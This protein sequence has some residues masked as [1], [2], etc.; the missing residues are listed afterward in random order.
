LTTA[1]EPALTLLVSSLVLG[2]A[3]AIFLPMWGTNALLLKH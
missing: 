2:V 1:M 3:L